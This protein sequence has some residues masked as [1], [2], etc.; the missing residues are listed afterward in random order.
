MSEL[1]RRGGYALYQGQKR[2]LPNARM[3]VGAAVTQSD[4]SHPRAGCRWLTADALP[5]SGDA[6]QAA[7]SGLP[8]ERA[9]QACAGLH[10]KRCLNG[11]LGHD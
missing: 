2:L 6:F 8:V 5:Q 7:L 3:Y 4:S 10:K 11:D 1:G 9:R